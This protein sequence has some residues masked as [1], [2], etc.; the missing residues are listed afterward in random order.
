VLNR[1][2]KS[3]NKISTYEVLTKRQLNLSYFLIWDC[4]TQ[5]RILNPKKVKLTSRAYECVFIWYVIISDAY[6]F[7]DL[8]AKVI[9]K[10]KDIDFYVN[11]Y[12]LIYILLFGS[13]K[14]NS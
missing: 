11:N 7:Y 12:I 8:N 4:L 13:D 6:R 3:K 1:I 14:L 2:L 10:F 5:V 9:I